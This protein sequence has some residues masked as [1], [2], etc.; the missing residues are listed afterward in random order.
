MSLNWHRLRPEEGL[1]RSSQSQPHEAAHCAWK[2]GQAMQR[3]DAEQG[4][5]VCDGC[6]TQA[7]AGAEQCMM[8]TGMHATA[9]GMLVSTVSD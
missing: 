9:A 1:L 7:L 8:P 2:L 5:G 4:S 3:G 6:P